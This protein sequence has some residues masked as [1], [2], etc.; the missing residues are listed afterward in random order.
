MYN[1]KD[2]VKRGSLLLG[3][4]GLLVGVGA[5]AIPAFTATASA[6]ALNPLTK[7][8]LTLSSSS[9][10]WAFTDGSGNSTYAPPNSGANGQKTGNTF[11]FNVSTNSTAAPGPIKTMSFQYCTK[12]AGACTAPGDDVTHGTDTATTSDLKVVTSTPHEVGDSAN[13][14]TGTFSNFVNGTSGATDGEVTAVPNR[15]ST[16]GNYVVYYRSSDN[17]TPTD[18]TDDTWVQSTGWTMSAT[19]DETGAT[20]PTNQ[21]NYIV[22]TN[23]TGLGIPSDTTVR[24]VFF[25]TDG[26][27]IENPGVGAFFVKINTYSNTYDGS[28][29]GHNLASLEPASDGNVIDGGVT[30]ANV[31]NQ[32]IQITTKVLETMDFSV[33]TVDPDTLSSANQSNGTPVANGDGTQSAYESA[34]GYAGPTGTDPHHLH[35]ECDGVLTGMTPASAVNTLALGD[36]TAE[37]SLSTDATYS[38]HSY[39]RLSSN[40]SGG[41]TIYYSGNTL[42]N[43]EGDQINAIGTTKHA[44]TRSSPQFGLALDNNTIA[45]EGTPGP[46][47]DSA[48]DFPVDYGTEENGTQG[49]FENAADNSVTGV[50]T[51]QAADMTSQ[52]FSDYHAPELYPLIPASNYDG[53]TGVINNASGTFTGYGSSVNTNFAFDNN[54]TLIPAE[55]ATEN[56]KVVDCITGKV[57]YIAD[58]AATTPAG[59]Y[60]T[61]VNYIASPQ[62]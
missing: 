23:S 17:G 55:I 32:S 20:S 41:A 58:I 47:G 22:L 56:S 60:T 15:N 53:G 50:D 52:G 7:R 38:T 28:T 62:Y 51:S 49:A 40:S 36:Q 19:H 10:G 57:R 30:V 48:H 14:V 2:A 6:D 29:A 59:I 26:T 3:A 42:A 13:G 33:G 1:I 31:M 44:P 18:P 43:T 25:G 46:Q 24:V 5:S 21:N 9:P 61:K 4:V 12:S 45:T 11:S 27:Y 16:Q 39:F 54:S 8:S 37:S 35:G 34:E